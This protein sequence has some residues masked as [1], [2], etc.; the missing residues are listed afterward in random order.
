MKAVVFDMFETLVSLYTCDTYQGAE[1]AADLGIPENTF[2]S[3]WNPSEDA[4][5]RGEMTFEEIITKI[6]HT[7]TH[8][9]EAFLNQISK[10]RRDTLVNVFHSYRPDIID[11]LQ[12]LKE[13]GIK[14][15]LITNCYFEERDA[16][17]HSELFKYFD[18]ALMSCEVGIIKPDRA[19]FDRCLQELELNAA[20]C[21][22]VGDGGSHE[23]EAASAI[24]MTACQATWYLK[25]D[26]RHPIR[27]FSEYLEAVRPMD[28]LHFI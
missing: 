25:G 11:M 5:A 4:R 3:L 26:K 14:I 28:V 12:A 18:V 1:I 19:I 15:A 17:I 13:R 6:M 2:R 23:L 7:F 10:R 27:R 8:F 20:E 16:I 22:Y 9:D 21:L 24:G